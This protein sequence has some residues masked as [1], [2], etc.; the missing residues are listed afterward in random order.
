MRPGP[1]LSA[2]FVAAFLAPPAF[3]WTE[4]TRR[5]MLDEAIRMSPPAL[6]VVLDRYRSDLVH[7]MLDPLG[8]EQSE[9]HRQHSAGGY[10]GAAG[11]ISEHAEQAVTI[12]G[13]PGRLRLAVYAMGSAAH[14]VA[15]VDFPPNCIGGPVGDPTYYEAY[16]RYAEKMTG[17]FLVVLD[18]NP[19]PDLQ[20][21]RLEEFGKSAARHSAEYIDP[22]RAAYTA[23]GRP[24]SASD[25]DEKSLPFGIASLSFSQAVNDISRVWL[26]IW[27]RAGGDIQ[28]LPFSTGAEKT[29]AKPAKGKK[30]AQSRPST[31]SSER[32]R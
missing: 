9:D 31:G 20:K 12:I 26:A 28:G 2:A 25:F 1:V 6:T 21:F 4:A 17:R 23:D 5:R 15:D 10:G 3:A 16:R 11:K 22:I 19:S 29:D 24:R 8:S 32:P 30:R 27:E 14:F 7:G 13:Q 18:K